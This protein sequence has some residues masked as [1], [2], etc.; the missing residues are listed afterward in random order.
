MWNVS[1]P[2]AVGPVARDALADNRADNH[3][4]SEPVTKIHRPLAGALLA[5][6][7]SATFAARS[8]APPVLSD[9]TSITH[10]TGA[11]LAMAMW[12]PREMFEKAISGKKDQAAAR[13]F[14]ASL[15]GYMVYGVLDVTLQPEGKGV[16]SVDRA[17]LRASAR[18]QLGDR[19]E[20]TPLAEADLPP[21]AR[22]TV[23]TMKPMMAAMLGSLGDAM[24]FMV[25]KDTDERGNPLAAPL[26]NTV[27]T[28]TF[29]QESFVWHLPLV[30]LLPPRVDATTG[31][32]FPGDYDFSPFTGHPLETRR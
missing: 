29:D 19:P 14:L 11:H 18:L 12:F 24:E 27:V 20:R 22:T 8:I 6:C 17:A 31:D 7:A 1:N 3:P 13:K 4:V 5:L 15:N 9:E 25:F 30:S 2:E 32:T 28:L 21:G 16:V 23:N 26:G 10:Q